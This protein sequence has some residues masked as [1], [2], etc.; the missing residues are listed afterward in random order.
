ME[1][2]KR[3]KDVEVFQCDGLAQSGVQECVGLCCSGSC[4]RCLRD[5]EE[6]LKELGGVEDLGQV[7]AKRSEDHCM[8]S[9]FRFP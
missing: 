2:R 4:L 7:E 3:G 1:F 5:M 8:D 9:C 6:E